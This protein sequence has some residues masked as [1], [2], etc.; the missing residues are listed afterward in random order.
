MAGIARSCK[1][2]WWELLQECC[3]PQTDRGFAPAR[4][5]HEHLR[6]FL[7]PRDRAEAQTALRALLDTHNQLA[8]LR[9]WQGRIA[10]TAAEYGGAVR[11]AQDHGQHVVVAAAAIQA[12]HNLG[13]Q[14][15]GLRVH[16]A[17]RPGDSIA[18]RS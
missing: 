3:A 5:L 1:Q 12:M 8:A 10:D 18:C 2:A 16:A 7:I 14:L 6:D 11:L 9:A 15:R 4:P 13:A 17:G